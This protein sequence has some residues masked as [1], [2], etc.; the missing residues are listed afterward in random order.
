MEHAD[1]DRFRASPT[2]AEQVHNARLRVEVVGHQRTESEQHHCDGDELTPE[3]R[4][5]R[6]DSALRVGDVIVRK[7]GRASV[8]E[9]IRPVA[10]YVIGAGGQDHQRRGRAHEQR[11]DVNGKSLR[12]ALL[13]RM[14]DV[15]CG[16]DD[17]PGTLARLVRENAA[18]DAHRD[19]AADNAAADRVH[20]EGAA[21]NGRENGWDRLVIVADDD[22]RHQDVGECH[23]RGHDRGHAGNATDA[24]ENDEAEKHRQPDAGSQRIDRES[25]RHRG[26]NA[27]RLDG[28]QENAAGKDGDQGEDDA[29]PAKAEALLDEGEGAAAVTGFMLEAENLREGRFDESRRGAEKGHDP[30]PEDS[31]GAA[32]SDGR[33]DAD[34]VAGA[35]A[36]GEGDTEGFEGGDAFAVGFLAKERAEHQTE[37]AHLDET[38]ADREE[39]AGSDQQDDQRRI[40]DDL[41]DG[42]DDLFHCR[43]GFGGGFECCGRAL[44]FAGDDREKAVV[45]GEPADGI[46]I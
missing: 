6:V 36:A 28:R 26:R 46:K 24:A 18:F 41:V 16:G 5:Y 14:R 4:K 38:G 39:Q 30:H 42:G 1:H 7:L 29:E 33:C 37:A 22:Q 25:V 23:K 9:R 10:Q 20:S 3:A 2:A 45:G 31:A 15:G 32:E 8:K 17:G 40:P 35:D 13:R 12:K 11:V 27:V 21:E 43:L 34:D 44:E 19:R